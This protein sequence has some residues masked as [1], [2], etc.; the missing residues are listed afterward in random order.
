MPISTPSRTIISLTAHD[1]SPADASTYYFGAQALLVNPS[2]NLSRFYFPCSGTIIAAELVTFV[3]GTIGSS[4]NATVSVRL[5]STTDF[6]VSSSVIFTT[7][8]ML[9][10][11]DLSIPISRGDW[12]QG[13]VVYPTWTTNPTQIFH[14]LNLHLV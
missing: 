1:H 3:A 13:K 14:T 12:I 8:L 9:Y 2:E 5:N 7:A 6:T 10:S 11:A 4:G